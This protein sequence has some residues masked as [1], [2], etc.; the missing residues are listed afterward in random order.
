MERKNLESQETFFKLAETSKLTPAQK[1][2]LNILKQGD[3]ITVINRHHANG[4]T[5]EWEQSGYAGKVYKA[6]WG[7]MY[8]VLYRNGY[9]DNVKHLNFIAN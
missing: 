3:R 9:Q 1:K 4:G 6:F 8:N 5:W 7:L 2:I